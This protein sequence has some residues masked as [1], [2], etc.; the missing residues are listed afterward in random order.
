[1]VNVRGVQLQSSCSVKKQT[2]V[3][4]V[5][6]VVVYCD[7]PFTVAAETVSDDDDS[8]QL[9]YV[10][11]GPQQVVVHGSSTVGHVEQGGHLGWASAELSRPTPWTEGAMWSMHHVT[12]LVS[13]YRCAVV[14]LE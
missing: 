5:M 8:C 6:H 13:R 1:M 11:V 2:R 12:Y 10:P 4:T 3:I 7:L 9:L 14:A